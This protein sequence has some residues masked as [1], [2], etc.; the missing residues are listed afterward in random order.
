MLEKSGQGRSGHAEN[1][2]KCST[3]VPSKYPTFGD[4]PINLSDSTDLKTSFFI[5]IITFWWK[6]SKIR[7]YGTKIVTQKKKSWPPKKIVQKIKSIHLPA[8]HIQRRAPNSRGARRTS[9]TRHYFFWSKKEYW[10]CIARARPLKGE[11]I[12]FPAPLQS[13]KRGKRAIFLVMYEIVCSPKLSKM[14]Q[15]HILGLNVT[16]IPKI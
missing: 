9:R 14:F 7:D 8:K 11:P 5:K 12:P 4:V 1:F 16:P 15:I 3:R 2:R 6:S 10:R 13:T